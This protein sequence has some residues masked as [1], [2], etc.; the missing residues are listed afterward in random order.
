MACRGV[1]SGERIPPASVK[2]LRSSSLLDRG[3]C[4]R[5][6]TSRQRRKPKQ[7]EP[8][9][10]TSDRRSSAAVNMPPQCPFDRQRGSGDEAE[11]IDDD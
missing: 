8:R 11:D 1:R 9:P 3:F 6:R 4:R 5:R 10:N 7:K 2:E